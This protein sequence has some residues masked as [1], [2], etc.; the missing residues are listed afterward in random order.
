MINVTRSFMPPIEEYEEY[1]KK[2]WESRYL[3]NEGPMLKQLQKQLEEYLG[4]NYVSMTTTGTIS[5]LKNRS[6]TPK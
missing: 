1:L 5:R 3:T 2:I 4:V 6:T